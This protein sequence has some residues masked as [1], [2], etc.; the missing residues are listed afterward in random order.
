MNRVYAVT[1]GK[2]GVG[3][4]TVA[5]GLAFAFC[6]AGKKVLL[7]D[8]DAGLRCLDLML[9]VDQKTVFDLG[10]ALS[11]SE[12]ENVIY[13]VP[14]QAGLFLIPA[15]LRDTPIDLFSFSKLVKRVCDAFDVIIFDFPAGLDFMLY[16]CLPENT[17]FL[18]VATPDPVSVR[19]AAA[20]SAKLEAL[21]CRSK[22]IINRFDYALIKRGLFRGID[23]MID[24]AGLQLVGVV[25]ASQE[26][27]LLSVYQRLTKRGKPMAAFVRIVKRLEGGS[28][29]LP[30]LKKI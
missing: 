26:L 3:K 2:G 6:N 18:T 27:A 25:P 14:G 12:T 5:V 16:T 21:S 1:S 17:V 24:S 4:S 20:V 30:R 8:M 7:V 15:P 9:G 10:D 11:G 29:P 19:D 28:V 23:D 13:G 22:L